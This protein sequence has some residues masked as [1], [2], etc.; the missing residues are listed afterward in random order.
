MW[1]MVNFFAIFAMISF[2][3]RK[4]STRLWNTSENSLNYWKW[5][6]RI[7]KHVFVPFLRIFSKEIINMCLWRWKNSVHRERHHFGMTLT[8]FFMWKSIAHLQDK[9]LILSAFFH[10]FTNNILLKNTPRNIGS[11]L[12]DNFEN[13]INNFAPKCLIH[14]GINFFYFDD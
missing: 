4:N 10:F 7:P 5:Q 11:I 1:N 3:I 13:N 12:K 8:T 14:F 9:K 2:L 6:T